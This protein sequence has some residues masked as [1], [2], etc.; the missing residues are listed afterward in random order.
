VKISKEIRQLSRE[1]M[2]A[3][4]VD[5]V[6]NPDR[7]QSIVESIVREKPRNYLQLLQT[8]QRFLRLELDKKRAVI[9]SASG[10]EERVSRELV[11]TLQKKYGP[12]L[13][14]EFMVNPALL[15]GVRVRVGCDVW[16]SSVRSRLER[17]QQQFLT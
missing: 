11:S 16:D 17:L 4:Y 10:L 1:L 9:E 13:T 2:R 15:G 7:V 8:Y 14:T 3:S 5:G 12:G 6:L